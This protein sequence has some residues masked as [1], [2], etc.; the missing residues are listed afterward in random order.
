MELKLGQ[1]KSKLEINNIH[2]LQQDFNRIRET[3]LQL[4]QGLTAEDM[5]LQSMED[6]SPTKWHLAHT[7]WF[8]EEFILKQHIP[9]YKSHQEQYGYL[10][11]SYY[12]AVGNRHQRPLRGMLS[13][14]PLPDVIE[15]RRV[16]NQK[17]LELINSEPSTLSTIIDLVELGLHHEMQHQELLQTDILHALSIHPFFPQV[18]NRSSK[19]AHGESA[20]LQ[21]KS[22]QGGMIEIGLSGH[23]FHY[24]C[25]GPRHQ[26]YQHPFA[27]SKRLI[28]NGEWLEFIQ[29]KGYSTATL[30]LSEGWACN[31]RENWQAP[32]YWHQRDGK[33]FQFGLDGLQP[34]DLTAPVCHISYFEADAFA[35]WAGH[36]LPK[37]Q[38]WELAS[39]SHP[40]EGNFLEQQH[41]RPLPP[42]WQDQSTIAQLYG[43]VWEWTQSPF[44]PYPGFKI[45][46]GAIGEYNGKFMC[47]QFVLRGGS[48]ATPIQQ[49][50][51]SYRNFFYPHQRWQY[52]GLRLAKDL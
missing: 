48:C 10:F 40:M 47:G 23:S 17:I 8:F 31:Q 32:L 24:D 39:Q 50:R 46:E 26:Y 15:Y 51:P 2:K 13:R 45:A 9:D 27:L 14:P 11:N 5:Q 4:T 19:Q 25:E 36:R 1:Q 52:S 38:E 44:T 7:T 33:W 28:N 21:F 37:E 30:W 49:M 43:D 20:A 29:D 6:A 3:T 16:I 42:R 41:W 18:K 22:F 35:S 12:E 34:I